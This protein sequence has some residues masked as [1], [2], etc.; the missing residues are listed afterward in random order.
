MVWLVEPPVASS[1]TIALT[2][3]RSSTSRPI[4]RNRFACVMPSALRRSRNL[5]P[6]SERGSAPA[7]LQN[8]ATVSHPMFDGTGGNQSSTD[9]VTVR[10]SNLSTSTKT[11][12]DVNGGQVNPGDTLRYTITLTDTGNQSVAASGVSVV[13]DL[14]LHVGGLTVVSIPAGATNLSVGSGG[15]NG[16]GQVKVTGI[17]IPS[18]GSAQIVFDVT[19]AGTASAG[20]TITNT[21][22]VTNPSGPGGSPSV[23]IN[24]AA[25]APPATASSGAVRTGL[26]PSASGQAGRRPPK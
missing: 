11:V 1:A 12:S 21:A 7:S 25:S 3:T 14:P 18:G 15:V 13:D 2:I 4:G 24:V 23:G 8:T 22:V 9:T 16:T 10:R 26:R 20:S 17:N 19:I 5:G 6:I